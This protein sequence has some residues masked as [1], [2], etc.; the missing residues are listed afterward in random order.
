MWVAV[1]RKLEGMK[2][3]QLGGGEYAEIEF[4]AEENTIVLEKLQNINITVY[5][6]ST[7][8]KEIAIQ[9]NFQYKDLN[10]SEIKKEG[11]C[12]TFVY[13]FYMMYIFSI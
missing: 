2:Y 7:E 6:Y 4:A 13:L 10:D 3:T 5:Y 1:P 9:E 11:Q 8:K 12:L